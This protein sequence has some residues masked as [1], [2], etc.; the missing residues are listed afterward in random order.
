V[1]DMGQPVRIVDL[2]HT[3]AAQMH[4]RPERLEIRFTGLR[5]GEKL[6][7]DLFSKTEERIATAHPMVMATVPRPLPADFA[8]RVDALLFAAGANRPPHEI[9]RFLGVVL[10]EYHAP[11]ESAVTTGYFTYPYPDDF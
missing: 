9:K 3:Y 10:P 11:A 1:L 4:V 2:V 6:D 8:D 5:S 7:E